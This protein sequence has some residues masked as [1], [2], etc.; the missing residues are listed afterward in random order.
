ML[1]WCQQGGVVN[2]LI[3]RIRIEMLTLRLLAISM[4]IR[5]MTWQLSLTA[6][7]K[8]KFH[9][10]TGSFCHPLHT[11]KKVHFLETKFLIYHE[12]VRH[13]MGALRQQTLGFDYERFANWRPAVG[14]AIR[15]LCVLIGRL[16][17]QEL[18]RKTTSSR[19]CQKAS[20]L[21]I[22]TVRAKSQ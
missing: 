5:G 17:R 7:V 12:A 14:G 6:G 10:W 21:F 20:D 16:L 22:R 18:L 3:Y 9:S 4:W 2:R 1:I 11:H 13:W 15:P 19:R 8:N